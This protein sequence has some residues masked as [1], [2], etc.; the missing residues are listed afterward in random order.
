M[1]SSKTYT[2]WTKSTPTGLMRVTESASYSLVKKTITEGREGSEELIYV[3]KSRD[4]W[5][6]YFRIYRGKERFSSKVKFDSLHSALSAAKEWYS[7][8]KTF[9]DASTE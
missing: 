2:R 8:N 9:W 3:G 1:A 4:T 6:F 7:Q 5:E